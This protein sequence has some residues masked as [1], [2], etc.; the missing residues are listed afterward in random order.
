MNLSPGTRLGGW[1][2]VARLGYGG[3]GAVY[4]VKSLRWPSREA[5][6]KLALQPGPVSHRLERERVLLE[7]V[8]H[9]HVVHLLDSGYWPL[10]GTKNFLPFL[11]MEY[12]PGTHLYVW[13]AQGNPQVDEAL[14]FFRDSALALHALHEVGAV[15]RDM[16]GEN[17]LVSEKGRLVMVDLG[18][19]D[20]EGSARL[21]E[22]PLPPGT[23]LYRSPEALRFQQE[24]P[25]DFNTRYDFRPTDDLFALGVTWYRTLTDEFPCEGQAPLGAGSALLAGLSPAAPAELNPRIP[26]VVSDLLLRMLA[27]QPESR[28]ASALEVAEA[29]GG[30]LRAGAPELKAPLFEWE[31]GRS[32]HSRTTA[33]TGIQGPVAPGHEEAVV[34]DAWRATERREQRRRRRRPRPEPEAPGRVARWWSPSRPPLLALATVL[35]LLLLA[36]SI[37]LHFKRPTQEGPA[38]NEANAPKKMSVFSFVTQMFASAVCLMSAA[39]CAS[40][41]VSPWPKAC[42]EGAIAAREELGEPYSRRRRGSMLVD[43]NQPARSG[44][45]T[46]LLREGPIVGRITVFEPHLWPEGTTVYGQVLFGPNSTHIH[47]TRATLPDGRQIPICA[48]LGGYADISKW[49][50]FLREDTSKEGT[51]RGRNFMGIVPVDRFEEPW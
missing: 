42:P 31:D 32:P 49:V 17:L 47:W 33:R 8:R 21:T 27:P 2:I 4:L 41:P 3:Y 19:G 5:A 48:A 45:D 9:A 39:G 26:R 38:M 36:A 18:V 35:L 12:V 15:H 10:P 50:G 11:V 28:P 6:L 51:R 40:T 43:I 14:A 29:L 20:Y 22:A 25:A 13:A 1:S 30:L 44:T 23:Q 16:K 46:I 34:E 24:R 37:L 7:R